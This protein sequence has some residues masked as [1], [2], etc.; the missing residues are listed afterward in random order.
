[1]TEIWY[2]ILLSEELCTSLEELTDFTSAQ[3]LRLKTGGLISVESTDN[4]ECI[5]RNFMAKLSQ[6]QVSFQVALCDCMDIK[7]HLEAETVYDRIPTSNLMDYLKKIM[8]E[9][10]ILFLL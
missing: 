7:Q 10:D 4:I 1:M 2:S 8:P 5:L 9:A 6:Q 3:S